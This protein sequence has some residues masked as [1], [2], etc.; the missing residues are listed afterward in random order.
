[1]ILFELYDFFKH[2]HSILYIN[3]NSHLLTIINFHT[4]KSIFGIALP[5]S[6][7]HLFAR[8]VQSD[9]D[10]KFEET[11]RFGIFAI[12]SQSLSHLLRK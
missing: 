2:T 11:Q 12:T 4:T 3:K 8:Y 1:M 10:N 6:R 9:H 7:V 5:G